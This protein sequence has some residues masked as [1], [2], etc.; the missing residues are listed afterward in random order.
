MNPIR[1]GC[2]STKR[3][4]RTTKGLD[5][6]SGAISK[7][8]EAQALRDAATALSRSSGYGDKMY[9]RVWLYRRAR[10]LMN[11]ERKCRNLDA[12]LSIP[13]LME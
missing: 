8:I 6:A 3:R 7:F 5:R 4:R 13:L 10:R 11:E 12:Q 9:F 2:V 1:K